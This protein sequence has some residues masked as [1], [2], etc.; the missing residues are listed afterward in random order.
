MGESGTHR[1]GKGK[2]AYDFL[3]TGH[4]AEAEQLCRM[5]L[6]VD[7]DNGS[8][9]HILALVLAAGADYEAA[10]EQTA[11]AIRI[12]PENPLYHCTMGDVCRGLGRSADAM[13]FYERATTLDPGLLP[14]WI[15]LGI[16]CHELGLFERALGSFDRAVR[17]DPTSGIPWACKGNVLSELGR[18]REGV[19]SFVRAAV[20]SPGLME[21]YGALSRT[22]KASDDMK[23][24]FAGC[25]ETFEAEPNGIEIL[26]NFGTVLQE[27]GRLEEA[28][29]CFTRVVTQDPSCA[30]GFNNLGLAQKRIGRYEEAS[31][32]FEK[33]IALR[34]DFVE[35]YNNLGVA[36]YGRGLF[37]EARS[38]FE[39]TVRLRETYATGYTNLGM[40]LAEEGRTEAARACYEKADAIA[41]DPG[42]K[43]ALAT[44]VPVICRSLEEIDATR[45]RLRENLAA[46][47]DSGIAIEDPIRQIGRANFYLPYQG[48]D[49]TLQEQLAEFYGHICPGLRYTA[50]HCREERRRPGGRKIKIAIVSRHLKEHTI[51]NYMKGIIAHLDRSAFEIH[52]VLFPNPR[53][54]TIEF[55]EACSDRTTVVA[56]SLGELR[57][58][59]AGIEADILSLPRHRHGALHL[60]PGHEPPGACPV[61]VLRA[62]YHHRHKTLSITLSLMQIAKPRVVRPTIRRDSSPFRPASPTPIII[63]PE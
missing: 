54:G 46:L 8:A 52:T 48:G 1:D 2:K 56:E 20:L 17:I 33:A 15:N 37:E 35:A 51:G 55:I 10:E 5:S 25:L 42:L 30:H 40:I 28:V 32:S 31:G 3:R 53:D 19:S 13:D 22:L 18:F 29:E 61:R 34:P 63:N 47:P 27:E 38:H 59:V 43:V 41:P 24:G 23:E 14:A 62:P 16:T 60:F 45:T 57:R 58:L 36:C 21:A 9:R 6:A 26:S 49:R 12:D 7:P 39:T 44:L 4:L 11:G 50:P